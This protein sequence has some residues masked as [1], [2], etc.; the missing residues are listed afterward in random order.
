MTRFTQLLGM[1]SE[2]LTAGTIDL[3]AAAL[4]VA[5]H[6]ADEFACSWASLWIL[7][8]DAE[9]RVMRRLTAYCTATRRR[10]AAPVVL[11]GAEFGPYFDAPRRDG[12]YVCDDVQADP[13]LQPM[14]DSHLG[15]SDIRASLS[16]VIG[17]N[18]STSGILT[19]SQLGRP[20]RWL[21]HEV[22]LLKRMAN[23][24]S[25]RRARRRAAERQAR[26]LLS[27]MFDAAPASR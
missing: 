12:C 24:I 7:D 17:V 15:P 5:E 21:P 11:T 18:A 4:A 26:D 3:E 13:R 20:R 9:A 2:R 22:T 10:I 27:A 6:V 16:A 1:L 19:C 14:L 23:E 8:G 25:I